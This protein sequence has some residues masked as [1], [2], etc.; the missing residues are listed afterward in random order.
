VSGRKEPT[1]IPRDSVKP[2][3]PYG[4]PTGVAPRPP[5]TPRDSSLLHD[6][7]FANLVLSAIRSL[8]SGS[9]SVTLHVHAGRITKIEKQEYIAL[10]SSGLMVPP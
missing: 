9:G 5:T 6:T 7:S 1:P 8:A 3:P 10:T 4:P 2:N